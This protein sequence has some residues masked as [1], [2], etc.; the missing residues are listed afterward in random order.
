MLSGLI[1][2]HHDIAGKIDHHRKVM[3]ALVFD[4][5]AVEHTI[6]LLDAD[7]ALGRA[8]PVPAVHAAF[9]GEIRRDALAVLR[10]SAEPVTSL[11]IALQI[12]SACTLP[13]TP[14]DVT[15]MRKR[16]GACLW[17]LRDRGMVTDVPSGGGLQRAAAD[18]VVTGHLAYCDRN[19]RSSR[20]HNSHAGTQPTRLFH[21][22]WRWRRLDRS[23]ESSPSLADSYESP[24]M[25][26][27]KKEGRPK[28]PP[29]S[30]AGLGDPA[31]GDRRG[32]GHVRA[33]SFRGGGECTS[34]RTRPFS[35]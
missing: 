24:R 22:R 34:E 1:E 10:S 13:D 4:L 33:P 30:V 7:A 15:V 17:K 35:P 2:M 31:N 8:K 23:A 20:A 32:S 16:V 28:P 21:R 3:A 12:L 9:K 6:R 26:R 18:P 5:E 19:R 27:L 29:R 11:Q 25:H 14:K